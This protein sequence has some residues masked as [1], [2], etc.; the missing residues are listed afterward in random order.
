MAKKF[1]ELGFGG[2][3]EFSGFVTEAYNRALFL[4]GCLPL[5]SRLRR[6]DPEISVVRN[7][8]ATLARGV[9]YRWETPED[10]SDG[11]KQAQDFAYSAL[12]DIEGGMSGFTDTLVSN[13][14]FYG[15]GWWE[16]LPGYRDPNW[17]PP[18]DDPWRSNA[19][20]SK[21]G[22]RRFAW[23]DPSTFNGWEFAPNGRLTGMK[24]Y[25]FNHAPVT[26]PLDNSLH[27]TF[28]DSHNPEGLSPLEAVWRL[29]RI[30]YGLEVVQGIG[31]E[32]AAG[33]LSVTTNKTL[34]DADKTEIAKAAR[35]ILTAQEGNYAAWPD[36]IVGAIVDTDFSAEPVHHRVEA[37][38]PHTRAV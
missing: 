15:W 6:S 28:G 4:P 11:D 2:L 19:N 31:F 5:Y 38:Q 3:Q 25:A 35:A 7:L 8:F 37:H 9:T 12:D 29:E 21:I 26:L 33:H 27:V 13:T 30:K 36:G 34:T 20:D 14:P 1:D 10:A 32:H 23:R 17:R 16:S 18:N 22:I 24:Q